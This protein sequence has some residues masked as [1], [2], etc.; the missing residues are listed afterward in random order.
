[1]EAYGVPGSNVQPSDGSGTVTS[2]LTLVTLTAVSRMYL[3]GTNLE[4]EDHCGH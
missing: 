2:W 1:M 3:K 4:A